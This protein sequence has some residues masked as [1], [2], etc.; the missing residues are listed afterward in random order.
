MYLAR[1]QLSD[2]LLNEG[3][4]RWLNTLLT[5][6]LSDVCLRL[7]TSVISLCLFGM[8]LTFESYDQLS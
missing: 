4:E 7:Y 5:L 8:H 3:L 2:T 6:R 1:S